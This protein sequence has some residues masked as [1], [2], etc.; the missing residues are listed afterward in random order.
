M[1]YSW[2]NFNGLS[3]AVF[4]L[5]KVD[6]KG[7][8]R[9][10]VYNYCIWSMIRRGSDTSFTNLWSLLLYIQSFLH[11]IE[12]AQEN[13]KNTILSYNIA[14]NSKRVKRN[15]EKVCVCVCV[16]VCLDAG[17]CLVSTLSDNKSLKLFYE[18]KNW[19]KNKAIICIA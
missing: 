5:R 1:V 8:I 7:M 2:S 13:K 15:E 12:N 9:S 6:M 17:W 18:S 16:C 10:L 19:I 14:A 3:K 4:F 11:Y